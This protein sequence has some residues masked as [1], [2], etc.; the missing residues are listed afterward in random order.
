MAIRQAETQAAVNVAQ[1]FD[2]LHSVEFTLH[3]QYL[4]SSM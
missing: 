1:Q 2:K 3:A 4:G